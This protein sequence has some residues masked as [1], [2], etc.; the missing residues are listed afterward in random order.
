[1]HSKPNEIRYYH[2]LHHVRLLLNALFINPT[3]FC[4]FMYISAPQNIQPKLREIIT[5][6]RAHAYQINL[7]MN[8]HG[9]I[10]HLH[11]NLRFEAVRTPTRVCSI[12]YECGRWPFLYYKHLQQDKKFH[13]NPGR[14]HPEATASGKNFY[15]PR[16]VL[17]LSEIRRSPAAKVS[18]ASAAKRV[19]LGWTSARCLAP[20][21]CVCVC[22]LQRGFCTEC[23]LRAD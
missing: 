16:K 7:C 6:Q 15:I 9:F 11:G 21:V 10:F 23:V 1:M 5:Q 8:S 2:H 13:Y 4:G 17:F 18:F 22:V 19:F 12:L 3:L 14:Q 20:G